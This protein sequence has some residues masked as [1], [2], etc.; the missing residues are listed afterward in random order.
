MLWR[1]LGD[2]GHVAKDRRALNSFVR[3]RFGAQGAAI[4]DVDMLRDGATIGAVTEA[5]KAMCR[6]HSI[7]LDA[8]RRRGTG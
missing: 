8:P 5:L 3:T 1:L 4:L 6:R 7:P 2:A